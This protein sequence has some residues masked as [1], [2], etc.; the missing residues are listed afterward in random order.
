[1]LDEPNIWAVMVRMTLSWSCVQMPRLLL[2][3]LFSS[4]LVACPST[5]TDGQDDSGT[6]TCNAICE[7]VLTVRFADATSDFQVQLIGVGFNTL[8]LAC[9]IGVAAGG[10]GE[11]SCLADGFMV[12]VTDY[13]FPE[14]LEMVVDNA[15]VATTLAPEWAEEELCSTTCSSADV[16]VE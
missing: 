3:S 1:M 16:V 11:A 2:A 12:R 7:A 4:I 9:P 10:F 6:Q 15:D 5:S 8:N 14:T 13:V